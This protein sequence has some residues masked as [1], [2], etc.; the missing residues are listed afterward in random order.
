MIFFLEFS[1]TLQVRTKQNDNFYFLSFSALSNL[2]WL[3]MMPYWFYDNFLTCFVISWEFSITCRVG[4]ERNGTIILIFSL[5]HPFLTYFGL[6]WSHN[7]IFLFFWQFLLFF[8]NFLLRV[9]LE[10]NVTM[11]FIFSLSQPFTTY[12]GKNEAI[13]VFFNLLHFFSIFLKFCTTHGVGTK[14]NDNFHFLSFSFFSTLFW[15]LLK[16]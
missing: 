10:R 14:R 5:S 2:F 8:W 13:M 4:T 1:F 15:L 3:D 11:I 7:S 16:P 12:C 6:K 9:G